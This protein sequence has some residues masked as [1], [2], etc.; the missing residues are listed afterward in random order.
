MMAA[1]ER[2]R[3]RSVEEAVQELAASLSV[4]RQRVEAH[5]D[6]IDNSDEFGKAGPA[7]GKPRSAPKLQGGDAA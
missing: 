6:G 2:E 4:L 5:L 3:L 1:E 7:A